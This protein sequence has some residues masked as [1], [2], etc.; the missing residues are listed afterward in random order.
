MELITALSA[1][2]DRASREDRVRALVLAGEGK[3]FCAGMDLKAVQL[4][5]VAMG[6]M[7]R[8]LSRVSRQLRRLMV[9][10]VS[11]VQGA[12]SA[13]AAASWW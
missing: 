5:P 4:D 2:L 1:A 6:G 8:M 10:T 7:L 11:A 13:A 9:P 3:S 12:R